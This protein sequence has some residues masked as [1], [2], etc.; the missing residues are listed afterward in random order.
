MV[1]Q[2]Q[3]SWRGEEMLLSG[4]GVFSALPGPGPLP[5]F[6]FDSLGFVAT[7]PGRFESN[8]GAGTLERESPRGVNR[9]ILDFRGE[10]LHE[11]I[12]FRP[13]GEAT[14]NTVATGVYRRS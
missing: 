6:W 7:R 14:F 1:V 9:T 11:R 2:E 5:W 13:A 3:H 12:T 10:D 8:A 4:H